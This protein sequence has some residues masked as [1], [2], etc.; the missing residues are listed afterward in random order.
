MPENTFAQL[1]YQAVMNPQ[2]HK[3]SS[4]HSLTIQQ[5]Q[6]NSHTTSA[7]LLHQDYV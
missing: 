3:P 2:A 6:A 4:N 5:P 7:P 1:T